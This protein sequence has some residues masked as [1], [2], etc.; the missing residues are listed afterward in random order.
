MKDIFSFPQKYFDFEIRNKLFDVKD[1][2]GNYIW[3]IFH[4]E[5]YM[6]CIETENEQH[7][8]EYK[9][10]RLYSILRT[11]RAMIYTLLPI[12]RENFFFL[13]SRNRIEGKS[14]DHNSYDIYKLVDSKSCF[15]Y[16]T[17]S[18]ENCIYELPRGS[19]SVKNCLFK[20]FSRFI[21]VDKDTIE[22][23]YKITKSQLPDFK[24]SITYFFYL[25]KL[26]Y[27][28]L[29]FYKK[30]FKLH[31]TKKVYL[32]QNGI[33]K[34]LFYAA[35][36]L[37]IN[38]IE[39]QH[40]VV[41][42]GHM[43]YSYPDYPHIIEKTY[44]PFLISAMSNFWFS[45]FN[46]P[47]KKVVLGNTYYSKTVE[48]RCQNFILIISSMLIGAD[49][50]EFIKPIVACS[51]EKFVFKLH[52]NEFCNV[53]FY[54]NEFKDFENISVYT[55]EY[56][57]SELL[58]GAKKMITVGSTCV[59]E[60]LQARVPVI[61]YTKSHYYYQHSHILNHKGISLCDSTD[62]LFELLKKDSSFEPTVFFEPFKEEKAKEIINAY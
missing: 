57:I 62:K 21:Q 30:L 5:V 55:N 36:K 35:K 7:N 46:L 59:Y 49:L 24:L 14:F 19:A 9:T 2:K 18:L 15:L 41:Y 4:Y 8:I 17:Y 27:F 37:G 52:P 11:L 13:A 40:G 50:L 28:D 38:L 32:T 31:G 51:S 34:G 56:T 33:Q 47:T 23:L 26:F 53:D 20:L 29:W 61:L 45:D 58:C 12:K 42:I 1:N 10:K 44:M 6:S 16:E 60:A 25:Y 43:A 22:I 48:R 3:D 39:C 54:K